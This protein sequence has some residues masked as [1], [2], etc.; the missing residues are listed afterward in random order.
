M[1]LI[2]QTPHFDD[3]NI[4]G[5][6]DELANVCNGKWYFTETEI[7]VASGD[8]R[9]LVNALPDICNIIQHFAFESSRAVALEGAD[10]MGVSMFSDSAVE[11][12]V[13]QD[14]AQMTM[15]KMRTLYYQIR[16]QVALKYDAECKKSSGLQ[17]VQDSLAVASS[18]QINER[19]SVIVE[20]EE[21][22][23]FEKG[24]YNP[25]ASAECTL[26]S[27]IAEY[28]TDHAVSADFETYLD[29]IRINLGL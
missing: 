15:G 4:T 12:F 18:V 20:M 8:T 17:Y 1:Q 23:L 6:F 21:A 10:A 26:V 3:A 24:A 22:G 28:I 7:F 27:A 29:V 9:L 11:E 2:D 16:Q 5:R 14:V 25:L 13:E 19:D